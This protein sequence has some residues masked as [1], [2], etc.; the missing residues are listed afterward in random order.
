MVRI[1]LTVIFAVTFSIDSWS[2]VVPSKE[3]A[4]QVLL[5]NSQFKLDSKKHIGCRDESLGTYLSRLIANGI[6][7]D[8]HSIEVQCSS[9][10]KGGFSLQ[11]K[12][13]E[14]QMAWFCEFNAMTSDEAGE[15]PWNYKLW[16][17]IQNKTGKLDKTYIMCPG[18]P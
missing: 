3:R 2:V 9:Q 15:S 8:I 12:K 4:I 5:E 16:F 6:S 7:G 10:P 17:M 18:M 11:G 14:N 1:F 13:F